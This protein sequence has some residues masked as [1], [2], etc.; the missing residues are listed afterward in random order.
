MWDVKNVDAMLCSVRTGTEEGQTSR[1]HSLRMR[2]GVVAKTAIV[3]EYCFLQRFPKQSAKR[4]SAPHSA[5]GSFRFLS[6]SQ[7]SA[8]ALLLAATAWV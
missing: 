2:L 7:L 6:S 8:D 5:R 1:S 4:A 3:I